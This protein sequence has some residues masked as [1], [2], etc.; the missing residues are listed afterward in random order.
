MPGYNSWANWHLAL[1]P[2]LQWDGVFQS[3]WIV[4]YDID[5][6]T[7]GFSSPYENTTNNTE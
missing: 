1:S 5:K 4:S 3:E 2:V 6:A 7:I